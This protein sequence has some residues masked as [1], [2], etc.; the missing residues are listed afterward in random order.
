MYPATLDNILSIKVRIHERREEKFSL[1]INRYLSPSPSLPCSVFLSPLRTWTGM[2]PDRCGVR[3]G[4]WPFKRLWFCLPLVSTLVDMATIRQTQRL[5]CTTSY[6][7]TFVM[8][9]EKCR[10]QGLWPKLSGRG[11]LPW[12][13]ENSEGGAGINQAEWPWPRRRDTRGETAAGQRAPPPPRVVG[14]IPPW[15][16]RWGKADRFPFSAW[17]W[18]QTPISPR[19]RWPAGAQTRTGAQTTG[20][21]A[22][23]FPCQLLRFSLRRWQIVGLPGLHNHASYGT[24]HFLSLFYYKLIPYNKYIGSMP[25]G[26]L[27]NADF[28]LT[29]FELL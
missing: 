7:I 14:G 11:R 13:L 28:Y 18:A 16:T 12:T 25:L 20:P 3:C 5:N 6:L 1:K 2:L 4:M 9:P 26:T 23:S 15:A 22:P 17:R 29:Q 21:L 19:C 8:M 24:N 10:V 27:T